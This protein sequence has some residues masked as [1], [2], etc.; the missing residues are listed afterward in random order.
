MLS[1]ITSL[2]L[3]VFIFLLIPTTVHAQVTS[4]PTS[5]YGFWAKSGPAANQVTIYWT[6]DGTASQYDVVYG[7]TAGQYTWG[8]LNIGAVQDTVN[9]YTISALTPGTTYYIALV[10]KNGDTFVARTG[11]VWARAAGGQV[12]AVAP[13]QPVQVAQ[14]AA[15]VAATPATSSGPVGDFSFR[16]ASGMAAGTADLMWNDNGTASQYA[17][18]YGTTSGQYTFGVQGIQEAPNQAMKFTV[19]ALTPG[20]TYYFVLYAKQGDQFVS[21]SPQVWAKA[22]GGAVAVAS[23]P[24]AQAAAVSTPVASTGGPVSD[25]VFSAKTGMTSGTIDLMW[26]DRDTASKYA[27]LYGTEPG[28]YTFGVQPIAEIPNQSMSFTVGALQSGKRYY[29]ALIAENS[30]KT[31]Y[32]T[33][34]VSAVAR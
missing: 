16:A 28:K 19:G 7:T 26:I 5:P 6:D 8:A 24:V 27:I 1:Y 13:A 15:P 17:L 25:Y 31:A 2:V 12:V 18:A 23:A 4:G 22:T 10:A 30:G 21:T 33:S 14:A 11:P 32:T 9:A 20:T 3:S 29:F 34:A